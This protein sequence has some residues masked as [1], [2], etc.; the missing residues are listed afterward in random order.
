MFKA[1]ALLILSKAPFYFF[2]GDEL[3]EKK[4]QK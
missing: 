3:D 1:T 4:K 2:G